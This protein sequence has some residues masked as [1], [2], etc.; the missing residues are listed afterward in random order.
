MVKDILDEILQ[1]YLMGSSILEISDYFNIPVEE[2]NE[3]IDRYS[4]YL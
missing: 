1:M 2:I 3:V 4:P